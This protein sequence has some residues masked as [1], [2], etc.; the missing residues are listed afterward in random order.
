MATRDRMD[1]RGGSWFPPEGCGAEPVAGRPTLR[2]SKRFVCSFARPLSLARRF[3]FDRVAGDERGHQEMDRRLE[4][5]AIADHLQV[6]G[7]VA[8]TSEPGCG[9]DDE[10]RR[11]RRIGHRFEVTGLDAARDVARE[12]IARP[13]PPFHEQHLGQLGNVAGWAFC[14]IAAVPIAFEYG[15][16]LAQDSHELRACIGGFPGPER[17]AQSLEARILRAP[18]AN[19]LYHR[20]EPKP[21][22]GGV[23]RG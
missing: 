20:L 6:R 9:L 14:E 19:A 17:R 4:C 3:G 8:M 11:R 7:V 16:E 23:F 2:L 22:G 18:L 10:A 12:R 5:V 1:A 15:I 21:R 13:A